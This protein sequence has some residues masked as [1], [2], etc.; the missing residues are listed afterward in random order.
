MKENLLFPEE[1]INQLVDWII[2]QLIEKLTPQITIQ[3]LKQLEQTH[4]SAVSNGFNEISYPKKLLTEDGVMKLKG[5]YPHLN[6]IKIVSG[7]II[8][9]AAKDYCNDQQIRLQ[10]ENGR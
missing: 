1:K 2:Q 9:P 8:T 10:R 7:T 5:Q 4:F 6:C 3:I